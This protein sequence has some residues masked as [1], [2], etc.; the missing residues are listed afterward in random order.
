VTQI[1]VLR[2][3]CPVCGSNQLRSWAN[4]KHQD[5]LLSCDNRNHPH[6]VLLDGEVVSLRDKALAGGH[7]VMFYFTL[8]GHFEIPGHPRVLDGAPTAAPPTATRSYDLDQVRA[9]ARAVL[10]CRGPAR[11]SLDDVTDVVVRLMRALKP[12]ESNHDDCADVVLGVCREIDP[13]GASSQGSHALPDLQLV[14]D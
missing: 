7:Q 5:L 3:G 2:R 6:R 1:T 9:A 8:S 12:A 14:A 11:V 10:L 4:P 13:L